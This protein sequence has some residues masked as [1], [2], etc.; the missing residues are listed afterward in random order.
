MTKGSPLAD[1]AAKL[2]QPQPLDSHRSNRLSA[3]LL[4][5]VVAAAPLPF[6]SNEPAVLAF[7]CVCLG[8]AVAATTPIFLRRAQLLPFWLVASVMLGYGYVLH[9]QLAINPWYASVHPVWKSAEDALRLPLNG[10]VSIIKEQPLFSLGPALCNLLILLCSYVICADR[11][12]ARQLLLVVAWSGAAYAIYGITSFLIAPQHLLWLAKR[13]YTDSLTSTFVNRNT[14]AIYFGMCSIVWLLLLFESAKRVETLRLSW[15]IS[16]IAELH[17]PKNIL[18]IAGM[19]LLCLTAMFMTNSRA[20]SIFSLLGCLIAS[21]GFYFRDLNSAKR[22]LACAAIAFGAVAL[23]FLIMG[24]NV[25]GRFDFQSLRSEGRFATYQ[26]V[27]QMIRDRPWLGTGL[28][29]FATAFTAYRPGDVSI[30]GLWD[31]A[32]STPLELAAEVGVPLTAIIVSVWVIGLGLLTRGVLK[33]RRDQIYS[34]AA[35]AVASAALAHSMIDFS[36]QIPG[37][38]LI[39]F[40]LVGAGVSQSFPSR[41]R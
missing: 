18:T 3:A 28:G 19:T 4:Y 6:G 41:M 38:S 29:T 23:V 25:N 2:L 26:S 31:K 7:W 32:H 21:I 15:R 17:V 30:M 8:V 9:E 13:A 39:V 33:R 5:T 36:L 24:G 14:A 22:I 20:G 37:Y 16:S 27:L 40:A 12:R 1:E 11:H 34:V 35:L 10:S